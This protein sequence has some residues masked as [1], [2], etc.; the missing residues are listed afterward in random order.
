[1]SQYH[2]FDSIQFRM[3][4]NMEFRY[5]RYRKSEGKT[6]TDT[7]KGYAKRSPS[8]SAPK[9]LR[10]SGSERRIFRDPSGYNRLANHF[11][12]SV[13]LE[14]SLTFT[15]LFTATLSANF[16]SFISCSGLTST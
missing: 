6:K 11:S 9:S 12:A 5:P 10:A 4:D 16:S 2:F 7:W 15:A 1:L 13:M 8:D 14:K 3:R